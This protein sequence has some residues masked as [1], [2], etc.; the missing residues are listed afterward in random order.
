VQP[1]RD[2]HSRQNAAISRTA[3]AI[4]SSDPLRMLEEERPKGTK[5]RRDPELAMTGV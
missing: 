2:R 4:P 1:Q 5:T 3:A